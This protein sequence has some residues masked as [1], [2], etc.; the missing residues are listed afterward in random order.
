MHE[1]HHIRSVPGNAAGYPVDAPRASDAPM[2]RAPR[3]EP[4]VPERLDAAALHELLDE[5][6]HGIIV[7][8][9]HGRIVLANDAGRRELQRGQPL[10][11]DARGSLQVA[12]D[13]G[14]ATAHCRAALRAAV[15]Q[16]RRQL[17]ALGDEPHRVLAAVMPLGQT[18]GPF[19]V[20]L[21]GRRQPAPELALEMLGKLCELTHSERAVLAALLAG[22]RVESVARRRGVKIATVR[23]QVGALRAKLG[24]R[25]LEDLVRLAAELPPMAGALRTPRLFAP[26][27]DRAS[28][29][30]RAAA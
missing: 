30:E 8:N 9:E 6:D 14:T 1:L 15:Q 29:G 10:S 28:G 4:L 16:R 11:A 20:L 26:T 3:V 22:E 2:D 23:T 21:L 18:G 25:R 19:A 27:V 7:C 12:S 5:M 17:L 24:A 13:A